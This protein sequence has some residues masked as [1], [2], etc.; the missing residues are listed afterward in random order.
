MYC[1][2]LERLTFS[3]SKNSEYNLIQQINEM[4][5]VK[6]KFPEITLLSRVQ[7]SGCIRTKQRSNDIYL[8]GTIYQCDSTLNRGVEM[9]M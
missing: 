8:T 7:S 1:F 2:G 3:R 4:A 5:H 6:K 9:L